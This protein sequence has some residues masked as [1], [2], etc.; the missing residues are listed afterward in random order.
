MDKMDYNRIY[1]DIIT[2]RLANVYIGYTERHHI[3]PRCLGGTDNKDNLVKLSAREHFICHLLLT[4]MYKRGSNEY[5]KMCHA[6]IIMKS[7]RDG[8][9][10][11]INSKLYARLKYDFSIR[12]SELQSGEGNSQSKTYWCYNLTT[13]ENIKLK[14]NIPLPDGYA[15]GRFFKDS[16]KEYFCNICNEKFIAY[17]NTNRIRRRCK[18]CRYK[19]SENT[20]YITNNKQK[21]KCYCNGLVFD[22]V[23]SAAKYFN[24]HDETMRARIISKS[25]NNYYYIEP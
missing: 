16:N 2:N 13:Y 4:K 15:Y 17:N 24:L 25:N 8:K 6:F 12:M 5:Y 21:K 3:I 23:S 1:T 11:N 9:H 7:T 14:N 18:N 20:D 19:R 22:S 10:S